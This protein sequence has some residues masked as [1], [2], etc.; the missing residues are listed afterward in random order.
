M[1]RFISE[2]NIRFGCR[3]AAVI[4][5]LE[6]VLLQGEPNGD[7]WTLPGGGVELLEPSETALQREMREELSIE[8]RIHRLL[9]IVEQFF[10]DNKQR[11]HHELALIYLVVP[12]EPLPLLD[13]Q[14]TAYE[15]SIPIIFKWFHIEDLPRILYPSFLMS[16]LKSLPTAAQKVTEQ[17]IALSENTHQDD[18]ETKKGMEEPRIITI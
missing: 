2:N 5:L 8:I 15:G 1:T 6:H 13:R 7:Y 10:A 9:W 3:V 18:L 11:K 17:S 12:V 14:I 4:L 16:G